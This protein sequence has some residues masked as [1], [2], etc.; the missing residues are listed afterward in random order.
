MMSPQSFSE[1][2]ASGTSDSVAKHFSMIAK[3]TWEGINLAVLM[4]DAIIKSHAN[5]DLSTFACDFNRTRVNLL[6]HNFIVM[7]M[8]EKCSN[9]VIRDHWK[10][11]II[12][13][14]GEFMEG[15]T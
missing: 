11:R 14:P 12:E 3:A 5:I 6:E 15:N 8:F 10:L 2:F 9:S 13:K 7:P 1:D 4:V